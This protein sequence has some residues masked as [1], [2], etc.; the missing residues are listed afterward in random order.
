[1]KSTESE[2]IKAIPEPYRNA[3]KEATEKLREFFDL[4][5]VIL[6]GSVARG[7]EKEGSDLDLFVVTEG[8]SEHPLERRSQLFKAVKEVVAKYKMDILPTGKT[9]EEAHSY[10]DPLYFDL[11]ADGIILYEKDDFGRKLLKKLV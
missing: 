9:P 10:F 11:Y 6:F 4:S 3:A 8:L 1:M 5:C 2:K 7:E